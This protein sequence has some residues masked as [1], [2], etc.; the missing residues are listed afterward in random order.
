MSGDGAVPG[1][2]AGYDQW[3]DA[4]AGDAY[5]LVCPNDHGSLPPR[6]VCPEC[7]ESNLSEASLQLEGRL[8]SYTEI[9]VAPPDFA[10]RTPYVTAIADFGPVNLTGILRGVEPEDVEIGLP[11]QADV[12]ENRTTG[13]RLV[14]F[15]PR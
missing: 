1:G 9:H 14:V 2:A 4:L 7:G 5:Y 6:R 3:A 11:V 8:L 10:D 12:R 15:R 13:E